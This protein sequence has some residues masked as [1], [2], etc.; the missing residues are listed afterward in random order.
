MTGTKAVFAGLVVCIGISFGAKVQGELKTWHKVT[1][2]VEGPQTSETDDINPFTDYRLDV[3]F[4]GPSGQRF[5]VPGYYAADGSAAETSAESGGI[6]RAHLSPD[7]PGDWTYSVSF[8]TG[9]TVALSDDAAAGRPIEDIDGD[10]GA[11][12][13]K[14]SDK[15]G[16]DF[17]AKGRLRYTGEHYLKFAGT[18]EYFLKCGADAPETF[19]AYADFDGTVATKPNVPLKTWGPHIADWKEGDPTW[20]GGKGKGIIGALNYLSGKGANAVSF[21]TYNAGGDGDNVWP[22]RRRDDKFRYNCSK[23]DQWQIVFDH[24]QA[25]GLYLHFK[26]QET[27]NDD[28]TINGPK[29]IPESLDG[30]DLGPQR[31]LYYR[32]LIARFGYLLA[33]NWNLGEENTQ[34]PDQQKAMAAFFRRCDPYRHLVV[35]HTFPDWQE[36]VYTPLLGDN[37]D[38][39]GA[40]LQNDWK[41]THTRTLQWLRASSAAGKPWVAANDEQGSAAEGAVPDTGY[42]GFDPQTTGYSM[43]DIRKRV[44]WGNLMAGG[45]GVEYYFGYRLP[46]NDLLCEDYRSRDKS[47]DYG[48]IALKFFNEHVPF[49]QMTNRNDLVGN[50]ENGY[51]K[52]CLA[53][54]GEIYVIYLGDAQTTDLDLGDSTEVFTIQWYNPRTGGPLR[55]AG[56]QYIKGPGKHPIG[57]PPADPDE[58]WAVLVKKTNLALLDQARKRFVQACIRLMEEDDIEAVLYAFADAEPLVHPQS[59][60]FAEVCR[61]TYLPSFDDL[62]LI[63]VYAQEERA[64]LNL[65]VSEYNFTGL[66]ANTTIPLSRQQLEQLRDVVAANRFWERTI[67]KDNGGRDGY[68]MAVEV[69]QNGVYHKGIEWCPQNDILNIGRYMIELSG[70]NPRTRFF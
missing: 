42:K 53:K 6:W 17:R 24:A 47:W 23:L 32:E 58:D 10:K 9:K 5:V 27:E 68:V 4:A 69:K 57:Q 31:K 33:L 20:Q 25:K 13:I 35:I 64:W 62:V 30:G 34:T 43:H 50:A 7:E 65:R 48:R 67:P 26:T 56:V 15:T 63:T 3:T 49:W 46:Q 36:R 40:S 1:V 14:P 29:S 41:D 19:L 2:L 61:L 66:M 16:L 51:K 44:L 12:D 37:S 39:T 8:R 54:P 55:T 52:Y 60:A 28:N 18:G 59:E 38:L 21:I 22:F 45:A 70:Y 11:F